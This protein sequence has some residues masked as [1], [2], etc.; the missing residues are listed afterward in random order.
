MRL[1]SLVFTVLLGCLAHSPA[2]QAPAQSQALV[3]TVVVTDASREVAVA[4]PALASRI[5]SAVGARGFEVI[6]LD[7]QL[8]VD[9]FRQLRTPA[10]RHGFLAE[11]AAPGALIVFVE[12][13]VR[14]FG[15]IGGRYRWSVDLRLWVAPQGKA[16]AAVQTEFTTPVYLEHYHQKVDAALEAASPAIERRLAVLLDESIESL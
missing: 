7:P 5:E 12:A 16:D 13:T 8:A 6:A 9:S 3:A 1:C 2:L 15:E 4:P 14:R 10:L 11:T